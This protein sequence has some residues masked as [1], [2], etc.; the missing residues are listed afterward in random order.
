MYW[1]ESLHPGRPIPSPPNGMGLAWAVLYTGPLTQRE[2]KERKVKKVDYYAVQ[3]PWKMPKWV[4]AAIGGVFGLIAVGSAFA[5]HGLTKGPEAPAAVAAA[6]VLAPAPAQAVAPAPAAAV[7]PDE[8]AAPVAKKADKRDRHQK[9]ARHHGAKKQK[10]VM[11]AKRSMSPV[12]S[13]SKASA[14][15]AKRDKS[16]TRRDKDA[17]DK[18]L[19]L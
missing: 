10:N 4:G 7:A 8:D 3:G 17:L 19:G 16:S 14:I 12:M 2:D 6:P 1:G 15:L 13:D 5:I 18:L 11:L 9:S